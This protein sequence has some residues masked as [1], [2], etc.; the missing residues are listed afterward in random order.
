MAQDSANS[1]NRTLNINIPLFQVCIPHE[2]RAARLALQMLSVA[3]SHEA[4]GYIDTDFRPANLAVTRRGGV[5]AGEFASM[6]PL[7][8]NLELLGRRI[9]GGHSFV[10]APEAVAGAHLGYASFW[11]EGSLNNVFNIFYHELN[12]ILYENVA[13]A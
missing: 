12:A 8:H 10:S 6:L 9:V 2:K 11:C 1:K 13:F 4:A 3:L 5:L 7:S